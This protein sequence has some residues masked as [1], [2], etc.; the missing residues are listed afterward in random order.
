MTSE[1]TFLFVLALLLSVLPP[2]LAQG[3]YTQ[4]DVPNAIGTLAYSID[5]A[6]DLTGYYLDS[7]DLTH[8]FLLSTGA[9]TT[10]DYPGGIGTE[11]FGMNDLGQFVGYTAGPTVGFS[12]DIQTQTFTTINVPGS[13]AT[14]PTAINNKGEIVGHVQTTRGVGFA[15]IGSNYK[16]IVPPG[17]RD[18][19]VLGLSS[20]GKLV[21]YVSSASN[22][23]QNF[24]TLQGTFAHLTIPNAPS[25]VIQG[26]NPTGT[27]F[28]G[29]YQPS[30]G[31]YA[32]FLYQNK[33]LTALQF[34]GSTQT[35]ALGVNTAG[36]VVGTFFDAGG[37]SHGFT[38]IP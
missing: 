17:A 13:V 35:F 36:E 22:P 7:S 20:S 1:R 38:W 37:A 3:T 34:P 29:Y 14:Y 26:L 15:L 6:G 9:Y 4:I 16:Y 12:Y 10:I 27:A 19:T 25:A 18:S 5:T 33:I 8:G 30:S 28:V 32:G 24:I 11:I 21:G 31:V 23:Y 2:A